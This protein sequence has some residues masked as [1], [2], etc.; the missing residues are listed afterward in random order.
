MNNIFDS[1]AFRRGVEDYRAQTFCE[2]F[3]Q[4]DTINNP[5]WNDELWMINYH[6]GRQFAALYSGPLDTADAEILF[7]RE[8]YL[9]T[10]L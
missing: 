10:F 2:R 4:Y 1:E 6:K 9:G 8:D 3:R 7:E 5:G